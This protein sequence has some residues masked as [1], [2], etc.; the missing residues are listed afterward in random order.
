SA[1]GSVVVGYSHIGGPISSDG[2][3]VWEAGV[4]TRLPD[5]PGGRD[6]ARAHAVTADGRIA[7]GYGTIEDGEGADVIEAV[8]WVDGVPEGLGFPAGGTHTYAGDVSDDGRVV[9]GHYRTETAAAFAFV[10]TEGEGMTPLPDIPGGS[11][12]R[13]ATA[14]SGDGRV[15]GGVAGWEAFVWTAR[16]GPVALKAY[17]EDEHGLD[18]A[19]WNLQ[20]VLALSSDGRVVVGQGYNPEGSAEG[21]R[22]DLPPWPVAAEPEPPAQSA[23]ALSVSPNP[24]RGRAALRLT[25]PVPGPARVA[26][27][28]ALGR[29]AAVLH[30]GPLGPGPHAFSFDA[31][32]LLP[33]VY[34]VRAEA[35]G[36]VATR[37]LTVLR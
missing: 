23:L 30:A 13:E 9:V 10:W 20:A 31:S 21:W 18:L 29:E 26:L 22:V 33:G 19:G 34:L 32:A 5:L 27:Y 2:A 16:T 12:Y 7:V 17:L 25:L 6:D 35:G 14:V 8:R 15:V 11:F 24:T 4:M 36:R 3:F 28:D 37:A 1:D